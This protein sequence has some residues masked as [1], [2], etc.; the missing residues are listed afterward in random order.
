MSCVLIDDLGLDNYAYD[1]EFHFIQKGF[2][3]VCNFT[4]DQQYNVCIGILLFLKSFKNLRTNARRAV[5]LW[6][7]YLKAFDATYKIIVP[8]I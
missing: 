2:P 1:A 8:I 7:E 3:S 4:T 6:L 5:S